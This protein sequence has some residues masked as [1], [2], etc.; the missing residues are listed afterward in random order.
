MQLLFVGLSAA[1][2]LAFGRQKS[3]L[4]KNSPRL[5]VVNPLMVSQQQRTVI[6]TTCYKRFTIE[7]EKS[8]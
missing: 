7:N 5:F 1:I 2:P 3:S 4:S 8:L 6:G